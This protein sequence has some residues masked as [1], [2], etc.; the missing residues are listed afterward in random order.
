MSR[1]DA[2]KS[3]RLVWNSPLTFLAGA[4][5]V[6]AIVLGVNRFM[7]PGSATAQAPRTQGTRPAKR[8]ERTPVAAGRQTP[9]TAS[10]SQIGESNVSR[11]GPSGSVGDTKKPLNQKIMAVVNG[12]QITR[13]ELG[14][15]CMRRYGKE[16]LES[17]VNKH[18]IMQE[19]QQRGITIT[20]QDVEDEVDDMASKFGLS[21]DRWLNMLKT[22][23][24]IKAEQYRREIIWPTLA[25]RRLA[26]AR[27]VVTKEELQ[28]AFES[29]YGRSVKVRVISVATS[30]KAN[31]L[32]HKVLA[33]PD[34]FGDVAKNFSEDTN[35]AAARGMIPP[36]RLHVGNEE[37]ERIAFSLGQGEISKVI[38]AA[39]QYLILKCVEQVRESYIAGENLNQI[40]RQL[41]DQI[42]DRKLRDAASELFKE[43]QE[44]A[45]VVTVYN[46]ANLR[47]RM[48]GV[49]ATVNQRQISLNQL[50]AECLS[51][52]GNDVL[53]G[54]INR[55]ILLQ[56][57][58][59]RGRTV[60]DRAIDEEIAR[61]ADA[62]GYLRSDNSPDVEAWLKTVTDAD[63]VTVDL[64]VRDAV[65]PS[66]ALKSLVA[67]RVQVTEADLAKGFASNYG[68]R[69]R[70]LVIVLGNQRQAQRVW[71][72]ARE[73]DSDEEFGKL[74]K[75]YSI[76]PVSRANFG[77]VPPVRRHSGQPFIEKEAFRL[78]KGELSQIIVAGGNKHIIM[79]CLGRTEPDEIERHV[80]EPELAK[81]IREKKLR[82]EMA[83][84]FDRLKE[85]AQIDNF[86]AGTVQSGRRSARQASPAITTRP[87]K[88]ASF[89]QGVAAQ[90]RR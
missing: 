85:Y 90:P 23:R 81:D 6:L 40:K 66:V 70:V 3:R 21:K 30:E 89:Q 74:A 56:E 75:E 44:R 52:H 83:K 76:E 48:P 55:L 19:C 17:I 62:Y 33:A 60:T 28:K 29:Q 4:I 14:N 1:K 5:F 10:R 77:K 64:Y 63:G 35:S 39:N 16:V 11:N 43:L 88:R 18:L 47:Q 20:N 15:E 27:I 61:A 82:L 71:K 73:T 2:S 37:I 9:S 8:T 84:E 24:D 87:I 49:A 67:D 26:A 86:L 53:D 78:Q 54:E 41:H 65:W 59:R 31:E 32:L 50:S 80:I 13:T 12:Q 68:E 51:R 22:E 34:E 45:K 46:D 25:L 72:R 79:R 57:L 69:V 7:G 58:K 38:H 42:R 36:I